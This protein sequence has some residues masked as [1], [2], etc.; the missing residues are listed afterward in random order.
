M[1]F[2]PV[3][4]ALRH[5]EQEDRRVLTNHRS[6][7]LNRQ[8]PCSK[9]NKKDKEVKDLSFLCLVSYIEIASGD[10]NF[11]K[12]PKIFLNWVQIWQIV[13]DKKWSRGE[14]KM[15]NIRTAETSN[16]N[17]FQMKLNFSTLYRILCF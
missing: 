8:T 10:S 11:F 14:L 1:S 13:L 7:F 17:I 12:G 6:F 15:S 2:L 5:T 16:G 3:R 9:K 4:W